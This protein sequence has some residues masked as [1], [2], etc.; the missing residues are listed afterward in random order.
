MADEKPSGQE[1]PRI[2]V[3]SDWK[4]EAQAEKERLVKEEKKREKEAE[5]GPMPA[6]DFGAVVSCFST[7][8]LLA[9][10]LIEHPELE[11]RVNLPLAKFYI[12][13]L[14]VIQEKTKG[15]LSN[16]EKA[17]LD[18]IVHQLRMAFLEIAQRVTQAVEKP[19]KP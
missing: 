15:N 8:A 13:M 5:T 11:R 19:P 12:D 7:P 6:A 3:D 16:D 9:L 4:R 2:I 1:K 17:Q 14:G 10:G 18:Q